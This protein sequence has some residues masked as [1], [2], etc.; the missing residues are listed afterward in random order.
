MRESRYW[1]G[2]SNLT[3]GGKTPSREV[4]LTACSARINT[5]NVSLLFISKLN[6]MRCLSFLL[7]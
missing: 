5:A 7:S 2:Y 1:S 6:Q 4:L 3:Q